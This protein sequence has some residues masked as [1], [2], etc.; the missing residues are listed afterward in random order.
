MKLYWKV[1]FSSYFWVAT[2]ITDVYTTH[3]ETHLGEPV[4]IN[5]VYQLLLTLRAYIDYSR[6]EN[7]HFYGNEWKKYPLYLDINVSIEEDDNVE[8]DG[9]SLMRIKNPAGTYIH[10]YFNRQFTTPMERIRFS[11]EIQTYFKCP[12]VNIL[13][14][15]QNSFLTDIL[16]KPYFFLD[17]CGVFCVSARAVRSF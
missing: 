10:S 9:T 1:Y 15:I 7:E 16:A 13:A 12:R 17:F 4:N 11:W 5:D 2:L 14:K 3:D 6:V 8:K